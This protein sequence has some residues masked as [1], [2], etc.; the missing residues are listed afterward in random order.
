MSH[1]VI[2]EDSDAVT[3]YSQFD[4]VAAAVTFLEA[5]HNDHGVEGARLFSLQPVE[6]AVKSYV[7]VEIA[8]DAHR[9]PLHS[10]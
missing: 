1:L 7:R 10:P 3:H 8:G 4:D 9:R 6:F 5:L 2:H